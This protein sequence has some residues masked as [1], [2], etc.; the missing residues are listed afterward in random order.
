MQAQTPNRLK[1]RRLRA[2]VVSVEEKAG[3]RSCQVETKEMSASELLKTCRKYLDDV[4]TGG[5]LVNP[6]RVW[7]IPWLTDK[8]R[9]GEYSSPGTMCHLLSCI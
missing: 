5:I 3:P 4:E 6:G 1:L 9:E 7:G 8:N 2:V